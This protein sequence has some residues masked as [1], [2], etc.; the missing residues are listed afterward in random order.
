MEEFNHW[1]I[2]SKKKESHLWIEL[3][4]ASLRSLGR[5]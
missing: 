5:V 4:E 1:E 2:L 3:K